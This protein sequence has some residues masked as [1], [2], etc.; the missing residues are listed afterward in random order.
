MPLHLCISYAF[1]FI[2]LVMLQFVL[3]YLILFYCYFL[4]VCLL[5]NEREK[6]R[7]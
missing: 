4:N 7:V 2:C 5:F 1:Y 6:E 3:F